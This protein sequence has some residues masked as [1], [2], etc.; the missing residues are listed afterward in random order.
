MFDI[1]GN[2][3]DTIGNSFPLFSLR[4]DILHTFRLFITI[5]GT[6]ESHELSHVMGE[7]GE[8]P[9]ADEL[10]DMITAVDQNGDGDIDF[11]E[12]L[13]LMALRRMELKVD[14]EEALRSAFDIF[15]ADG[16]GY[17]D[18]DEVRLLMKKFA[19]TLT[20]EEITQIMQEGDADGDGEIS[21]EEFKELMFS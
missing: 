20:D 5:T 19:Q 1:D 7:L 14:P 6:I 11:E 12:F 2:G 16:S 13:G 3:M 17:I 10:A 15:D 18:R 8:K 21:F 4:R 9:T